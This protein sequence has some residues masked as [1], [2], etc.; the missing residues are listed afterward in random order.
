MWSSSATKLTTGAAVLVD[1]VTL[2]RIRGQ[3]TIAL[4]TAAAKADG[5]HGAFGIGVVTVPA[6][7]A[8]AASVPTPITELD[9]DGWLYHQFINVK[10]ADA[11]AAGAAAN[12]PGQVHNVLAVQRFDVDS[13]AM[14]KLRIND[15]I[16]AV[17]ELTEVG[18]ATAQWF[19]N[20][21]ALLKLA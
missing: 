13:K 19:F 2:V 12:E 18:T 6:F 10:A 21:R 8:G 1:G 5:Y 17:M 15:I 9:W 7:T 20:C 16:F 3:L 14:R 4:E 11:I